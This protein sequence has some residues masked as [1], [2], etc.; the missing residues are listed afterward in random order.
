METGRSEG[1]NFKLTEV[2]RLEEVA[3]MKRNQSALG[4]TGEDTT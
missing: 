1:Q 2:Q 4:K 3:V